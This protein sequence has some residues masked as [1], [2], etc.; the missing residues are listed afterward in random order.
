MSYETA[1]LLVFSTLGSTI[2]LI[3]ALM[4]RRTAPLMFTRNAVVDE[5]TI[6]NTYHLLKQLV[7]TIPQLFGISILGV[8][9]TSILQAINNNAS[10]ASLLIPGV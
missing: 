9:V 3:L 2:L 1:L 5:Q 6:R 4:E 7:G 10:L 8:L